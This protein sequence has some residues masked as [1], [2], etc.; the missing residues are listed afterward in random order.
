MINKVAVVIHKVEQRTAR[1]H[2][3]KNCTA[4]RKYL[5]ALSKAQSCRLMAFHSVAIVA[6]FVAEKL[7]TKLL[8]LKIELS[9]RAGV[10]TFRTKGS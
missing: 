6:R 10:S 1:D 5:A 2:S 7:S 4:V 9:A 3:R 8:E